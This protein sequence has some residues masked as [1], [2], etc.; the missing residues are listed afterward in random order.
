MRQSDTKASRAVGWAL[1]ALAVLAISTGCSRPADPDDF[2]K[3]TATSALADLSTEEQEDFGRLTGR[4]AAP[5]ADEL[6]AGRGIFIWD[7]RRYQL[8]NAPIQNLSIKFKTKYIFRN[9]LSVTGRSLS[10]AL[11][12]EMVAFPDGKALIVAGSKKRSSISL[13]GDN[14]LSSEFQDDG[15][16]LF[17]TQKRGS[18]D[19]FVYLD[20]K[21]V[22]EFKTKD[23]PS[24]LF[25]CRSSNKSHTIT[26]I[27]RTDASGTA[28][29]ISRTGKI[30]VQSVGPRVTSDCEGTQVVAG[31]TPRLLSW[32][33]DNEEQI[34]E[35]GGV[36][37]NDIGEGRL[38]RAEDPDTGRVLYR[39]TETG[40]DRGPFVPMVWEVKNARL[41]PRFF[42]HAGIGTLN[43]GAHIEPFGRSSY[44]VIA[45][46]SVLSITNDKV[47]LLSNEGVGIGGFYTRRGSFLAVYNPFTRIVAV[48]EMRTC[49]TEQAA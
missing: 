3:P 41:E 10:L 6:V 8:L 35:A 18:D 36:S 11:N 2:W 49:G 42:Y 32:Y 25:S 44:V 21:K 37:A 24:S 12:G 38:L 22:S 30:D 13:E 14:Y 28:Y 15:S 39:N 4:K 34:H 7:G 48:V 17:V 23:I 26:L 20:K 33:G 47:C 29:R 46:D 19:N 1:G 31:S 27:Q 43:G 5:S 45:A 16:L 40:S 9:T